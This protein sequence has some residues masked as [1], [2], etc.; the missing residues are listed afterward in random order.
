MNPSPGGRIGALDDRELVHREKDLEG[1][2]E[3]E[4]LL[5]KESR[6]DGVLAGQ[7]FHEGFSQALVALSFRGRDESCPM[8][9]GDVVGNPLPSLLEESLGWGGLRVVAEHR[10]NRFE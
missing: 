10:L 4:E 1:R 3:F 9:P 6:S 8:E 7:L 5:V 2:R